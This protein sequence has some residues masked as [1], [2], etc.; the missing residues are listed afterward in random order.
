MCD[1]ACAAFYEDESAPITEPDEK[2]YGLSRRSFLGMSLGA[3]SLLLPFSDSFAKQA[4]NLMLNIRNQRTGEALRVAWLRDGRVDE[5]AVT[6]LH[7]LMRDWRQKRAVHMDLKL[8]L[9]LSNIQLAVGMDREILLT[10]GYRT[11]ATNQMLRERGAAL[12]SYHLYG[13]AVDFAVPGVATHRI[14]DIALDLRLGGVGHYPSSGYVH[15]DTGPVRR[16]GA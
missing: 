10:S 5:S 7:M 4:P 3:A 11:Q 13:Q 16:W 8:Y 15:V 12:R 9:I 1:T 2:A 6:A 14:R